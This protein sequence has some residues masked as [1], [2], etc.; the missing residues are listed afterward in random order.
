[1]AAR[2]AETIAAI[3]RELA[4]AGAEGEVALDLDIVVEEDGTILVPPVNGAC[5]GRLTFGIV[6][7]QELDNPKAKLVH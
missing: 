1:M 5:C 6:I 3:A 4:A 2:L 7:S